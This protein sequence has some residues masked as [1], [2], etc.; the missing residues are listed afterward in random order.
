MI[1]SI[2]INFKDGDDG[3]IICR[4]CRDGGPE[5]NIIV[6]LDKCTREFY[7]LI[8]DDPGEIRPNAHY[9]DIPCPACG[10][11]RSTFLRKYGRFYFCGFCG[12]HLSINTDKTINIIAR[13]DE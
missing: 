4:V 7:P 6:P 12:S 11:K 3:L 1:D 5:H 8:Q 9:H 10:S 13:A 2:L